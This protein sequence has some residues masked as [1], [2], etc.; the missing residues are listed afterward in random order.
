MNDV[1]VTELLSTVSGAETKREN[2]WA[3]KENYL[4][5]GQFFY[6]SQSFISSSAVF[7]FVFAPISA[8]MKIL[9][10]HFTDK[11]GMKWNRCFQVSWA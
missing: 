9:L 3:G 2:Y 11:T 7:V 4:R 5:L 10:H 1:C 6:S 8:E